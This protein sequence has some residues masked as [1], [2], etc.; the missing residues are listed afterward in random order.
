[1]ALQRSGVGIISS[2]LTGRKLTRALQ[3]GPRASRV[4]QLA[5]SS[6]Q[7]FRREGIIE[8]GEED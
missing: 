4:S 2:F 7:K 1:M 3:V 8:V 6:S 5:L